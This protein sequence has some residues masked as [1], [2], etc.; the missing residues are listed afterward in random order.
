MNRRDFI[1]GAVGGF[2]VGASVGYSIGRRKPAEPA[3]TESQSSEL[4]TAPLAAPA[5]A[6]G[7]LPG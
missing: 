6:T 5:E 2:I 3:P 1:A 7:K 4:R